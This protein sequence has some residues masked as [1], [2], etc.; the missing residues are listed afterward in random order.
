MFGTPVCIQASCTIGSGN[1]I[2]D[3]TCANQQGLC[4]PTGSGASGVCFP[5]CAYSSTKIESPCAGGNKCAGAY[6]AN[7]QDGTTAIGFCAPSCTG[8][9]DCKGTAGQQCQIETGNCVAAANHV[10]FTKKVGEGCDSTATTQACVCEAGSD[11]TKG[12]CGSTCVTGT[13]G[14]A[15]CATAGGGA[16]WKCTAKL[17]TSYTNNGQTV[18]G[19][20]AQPDDIV[21]TCALACP[22]GDADCAALATA[23]GTTVSCL[24]FVDGKYCSFP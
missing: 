12:L 3:I 14:N 18:T 7:G 9:T 15:A 19:Y 8:D 23:A 6:L 1:T 4:V 16:N 20:T 24:D 2:N 21:G 10:V 11:A 22:N 17:K 13:A 5:F